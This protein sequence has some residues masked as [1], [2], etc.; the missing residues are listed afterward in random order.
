M[1]RDV[2]IITGAGKGIGRSIALK[3]AEE[4]HDTV[5][6]SR[7]ESD[8]KAV[9]KEIERYGTSCLYFIGDVAEENFAVGTI[10]SVLERF[11]KIDHLINNAGFGI[12]KKLIDTTLGEFQMQVNTNLFGVYNFCKAVLPSMI[13]RKSGSI[14]NI[15]SLAGKNFFAGGTMY[16]ATK[17]ALMGFSKSLLMEV[18]EYNIRVAVVCPGSVDTAFGSHSEMS[19]VSK[20]NIL[21]PEDVADTVAA[22]IKLPER[23]LISEVELRPTNHKK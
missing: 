9:R 15:S 6:L 17:H 5:I 12:F 20:S 8:L 1:G 23:A 18:R 4:G 14:I 22:I 3:L 19:P 13:E 10:K 2:S 16:T 21:L 7:T 11:G